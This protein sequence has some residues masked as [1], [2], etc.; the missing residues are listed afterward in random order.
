MNTTP[1]TSKPTSASSH[2][3]CLTIR[4]LVPRTRART[5]KLLRLTSPVVGNKQCSVVLYKRLL[6]LVLRVL[7]DVFLVVSDNGLCDGLAN[8]VDLGGVTTT[9]DADADVD[10]GWE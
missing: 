8:G 2:R 7:V 1:C 5:A 10:I 9:R 6:Q 3:L 4:F